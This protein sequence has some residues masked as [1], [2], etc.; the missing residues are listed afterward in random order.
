MTINLSDIIKRETIH[1]QQMMKEYQPGT[2]QFSILWS[3][4]RKAFCLQGSYILLERHN[5]ET[6]LY[7]IKCS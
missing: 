7:F 2:E 1:S 5:R 6:N 4:Q 3:Q